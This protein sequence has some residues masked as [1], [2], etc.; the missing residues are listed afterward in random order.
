MPRTTSYAEPIA[1]EL[2]SAQVAQVHRGA[3]RDSG[4][5]TLASRLI[6]KLGVL[7]P[8]LS[9]MEDRRLSKSLLS[10]L[11]LLVTLPSDGSYMANARLARLAGMS[12]STTHRYLAT[13]LICALV[14]RDPS[15]RHYRVTQ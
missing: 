5:S 1:I 6:T 3:L 2:S 13:L 15:T 8:P 9:A 10:G 12:Q 14:E 11:L 4:E 7:T